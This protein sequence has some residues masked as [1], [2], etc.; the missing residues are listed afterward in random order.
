MP[1]PDG[2]WDALDAAGVTLMLSVEHTAYGQAVINLGLAPVNA[3]QRLAE[4][5]RKG[6]EGR[7]SA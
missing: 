2:E 6:T 3:A 4:V 1:E 7:G 5:V